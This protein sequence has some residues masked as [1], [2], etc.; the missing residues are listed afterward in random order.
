M[1]KI[2]VAIFVDGD[3]I[4]SYDGASNRFHYLSRYLSLNGIDLIVFH[5]YRE[6]SDISLIKK[7]PFKTYIFPINN[8]YN[9]L[10]LIASILNKESVDI[11]QFDNLEPIL[12]QGIYLAKLTKLRLVNDMH[13]VVRNLAKK[14][15]HNTFRLNEIKNMEKMVGKSIDHLIS[16]SKQDK[17]FLEK[18]MKIKPKKVSV[19]SSGV[20]IN[21]IKYVGPNFSKKNIVFLGN[22]YFKP[23]EEAVRIIRNNIYPKLKKLGYKFTIAGSCPKNIKEKYSAPGFSFIGTIPNLNNFFKNAT[24]ALAPINE[25][26]G[27]RI[28]LLNYLVAGIPVLTT[29]I[30]T[31]GFNKKDYFFIKD[32]YSKYAKKIIGL[33]LNKNKLK[34][35]SKK[36]YIMVKESY[37][38]N[39]IAKQTI[40]VYKKILNIPKIEKKNI[41]NII[42]KNKEP[43]WLQEAIKKNR[44]KKITT[45]KLPQK[46]SYSILNKG[47]INTYILEK[48]IAIEGMPGA[49]KTTFIENY[50][51]S[52]KIKFIPQL[53][54]KKE[55][56]LKDNIET[57]KQFIFAEKDKTTLI[58]KFSKKYSEIILDRTFITTLAYCYARS[59]IYSNSKE[60]KLLLNFYNEV[61]HIITFPTHI[62][63]LD[64]SIEESLK[65]RKIYSKYSIYKNWFNPLFLKYF[66][67][68][69]QKE[70]KK[71]LPV[72]FSYINTNNLNKKEVAKKIQKIICNK[73]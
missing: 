34:D 31:S 12:L 35:K 26:T 39:I 54:I 36:G 13:Y 48:I 28:K 43:V 66:K 65:R 32:D 72:P 61:K 46:F 14:L 56:L 2:K 50:A 45:N 58:D 60:Y 63:Y 22:L 18:Y 6:W 3:F 70:L 20:D 30:A 19:I 9:N 59:K 29:K 10:E 27:M 7:E 5:G 38:W 51:R 11:I 24:F 73:I 17:I 4:P 55:I 23:N 8:Y 67:E 25:G 21:E 68:F 40:S 57:S 42:M 62:I 64:V 41:N 16:I 37:D 15:N 53:Q 47:E 49:G 44:F 1:K 33:L 69:Y 52:K 71:I